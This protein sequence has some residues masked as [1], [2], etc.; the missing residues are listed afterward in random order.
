MPAGATGEG[1][2]RDAC[3]DCRSMCVAYRITKIRQ[4]MQMGERDP[5]R[6]WRWAVFKVD[7]RG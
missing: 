2:L 7:R 5:G 4:K 3:P 6:W 1:D